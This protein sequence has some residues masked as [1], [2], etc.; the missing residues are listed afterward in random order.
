M[1]KRDFRIIFRTFGIDIVDVIR[2]YN[3][4]CSGQHPCF[5]D[6]PSDMVSRSIAV[7]AGTGEFFRNDAGFHL[8]MSSPY[9]GAELVQLHHGVPD[10]AAAL[11]AKLFQSPPTLSM[12]IRDC[13]PHWRKNK[14]A[15][16]AGKP[17]FVEP[18]LLASKA[19]VHH[20]FFDDNIE[21]DR[22]HIVDARSAVGG[23]PLPFAETRDVYL[24]KAEPM[25]A[26]QDRR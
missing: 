23:E 3:L 5:P 14:E 20:I 24:I 1:G 26:I 19:G 9:N 22:A 13:F 15:D 12:A 17:L 16:D 10:C 11:R 21:R 6:V 2:E 4:F 25:L 7:P 18:P 8:A